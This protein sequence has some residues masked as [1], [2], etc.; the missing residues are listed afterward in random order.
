M[1]L[2]IVYL[3][4]NI[5]VGLA[6]CLFGKKLF[7][8]MLGL[9]VFFGVFSL[10]LIS[11]DDSVASHVVA[12]V[13]GV[14]ALLSR[15]VYKVGVFLVGLFTGAALGYVVAVLL[16]MEVADFIGVIMVVASLC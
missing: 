10:A 5:V 13:L 3:L 6:A 16:P 12:A 1:E 8:L 4:T 15:H 11:T 2:V 9:L 14:A 7:Y